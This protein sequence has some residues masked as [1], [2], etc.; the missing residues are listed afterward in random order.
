MSLTTSK[1]DSSAGTT[2]EMLEAFRAL[3]QNFQRTE[4]RLQHEE[5]ASRVFG[6]TQKLMDEKI[7]SMYKLLM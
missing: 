6:T 7:N 5:E 3:Q 2:A 1:G 4:V